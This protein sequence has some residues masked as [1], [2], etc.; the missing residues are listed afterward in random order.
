MVN[1]Q[2]GPKNRLVLVI[3]RQVPTRLEPH[4]LQLPF[5]ESLSREPAIVLPEAKSIPVIYSL[6]AERRVQQLRQI[7]P[8]PARSPKA[9]LAQAMKVDEDQAGTRY[10][11]QG[12]V[13]KE[14]EGRS[15]CE[16]LE[17]G[18]A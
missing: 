15:P 1:I 8:A 3:M 9:M 13:E 2:Q 14:V 6:D 17:R 7:L 16:K 5:S 12:Y 11:R 18:V 10:V 4:D